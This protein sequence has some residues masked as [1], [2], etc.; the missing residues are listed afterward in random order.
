[1]G[2]DDVGAPL[3]E[4]PTWEAMHAEEIAIAGTRIRVDDTARDLYGAFKHARDW[5]TPKAHGPLAQELLIEDLDPPWRIEGMLGNGHN[6]ILVAGRKA[7]KTTMVND[8]IRAYVDGGDFLGTQRVVP[9]GR[10]VAVFNYEVDERQYRGWLR[11]VGI[12]NADRVHALHLRGLTLPLSNARVR[13]WVTRWLADRDVG[14]WILDPYSR[15]YLGSVD[16]GN[17]EAQVSAF[18]DTLDVIKAEAGV[19]ELVMPVH[20]PKGHRDDGDET[21][22]GSQRL[23]GWPDAM[24]YLTR[25]GRQRY[26]RAE[27][28]DVEVAEKQLNY[29]SGTRRLS[30]DQFGNDRRAAREQAKV[31][32]QHAEQAAAL[33]TLIE[34][35]AADPGCTTNTIRDGGTGF[36]SSKIGSLVA[37]SDGRIVVEAGP[38]NSKR[39]YLK[40]HFDPP[41]P[42][43]TPGLDQLVPVESQSPSGVRGVSGTT[44]PKGSP[45]HPPTTTGTDPTDPLAF[46]PFDLDKEINS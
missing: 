10:H 25:D 21:A 28:R 11:E 41:A 15:A 38:R 34:F 39:H 22:I 27:G 45:T 2:G 14:L 31:E 23:E 18:L 30:F 8:L 43:G 17:D 6:A 36:S 7:G 5:S 44:Y 46:D 40:G 9:N 4:M 1:V 26:L 32:K 35:I 12:E 33:N 37:I 42:T 3:A 29:E 13:G 24:W 19:S 16:N 20:T